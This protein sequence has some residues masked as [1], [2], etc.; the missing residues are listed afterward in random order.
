M[1]VDVD[2]VRAAAGI[3]A[4]GGSV[5][6]AWVSETSGAAGAVK[7]A[8]SPGADVP[9]IAAGPWSGATGQWC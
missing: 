8:E 9:G 7:C 1:I 4:D 5:G 2:E 6:G 3:Q